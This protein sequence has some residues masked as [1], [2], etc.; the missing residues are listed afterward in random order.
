MKTIL[1]AVLV[2]ISFSI[3]GCDDECINCTPGSFCSNEELIENAANSTCLAEDYLIGFGC[4][5]VG[6][7][8]RNPDINDGDLNTCTVIDCETL[9]CEEMRVDFNE[10]EP[11]LITNISLEE[12]TGSPIGLFEVDDLIGNFNCLIFVP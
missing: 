7:F 8:S 4:P 11:G 9:S 6:C 12:M 1:L 3:A 2:L 5:N 10:P